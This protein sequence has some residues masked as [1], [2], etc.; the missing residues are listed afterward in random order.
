[1]T[2]TY[3]KQLNFKPQ[4]QGDTEIITEDLRLLERVFYQIKRLVRR[5]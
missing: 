4:L 3:N 2:T 5:S 1:M